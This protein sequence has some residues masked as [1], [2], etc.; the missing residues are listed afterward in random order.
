MTDH[1]TDFYQ[2]LLSVYLYM[3]HILFFCQCILILNFF[4]FS[5]SL[6]LMGESERVSI[7][8]NIDRSRYHGIIHKLS[9]N[10]TIIFGRF[11]D[12]RN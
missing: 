1:T 7:K 5:I 8:G 12:E 9:V 2:I 10:Q 11:D 6:Q 3:V 4:F